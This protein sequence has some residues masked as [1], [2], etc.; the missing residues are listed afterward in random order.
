M[1]SLWAACHMSEAAQKL[2]GKKLS[3]HDFGMPRR[4]GGL[5]YLINLQLLPHV[6]LYGYAVCRAD[7]ISA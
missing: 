5:C 3:C 4:V 7:P 1:S 6:V 2:S